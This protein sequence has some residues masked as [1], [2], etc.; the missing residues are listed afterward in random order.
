MQT[1][2]RRAG[3]HNSRTATITPQ[4]EEWK[5]KLKYGVMNLRVLPL[6]TISENLIPS[7]CLIRRTSLSMVKASMSKWAFNR[8]VPPGVSYIPD[9]TQRN[10]F[11]YKPVHLSS[12]TSI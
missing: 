9:E 3:T 8:M 10:A 6:Y 2:D 4:D 7:P 1:R 12:S 5:D 11:L